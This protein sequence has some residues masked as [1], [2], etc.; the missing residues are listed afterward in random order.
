MGLP[1]YVTSKGR[2]RRRALWGGV[3]IL[4]VASLVLSL[5]STITPGSWGL[6][7]GLLQLGLYYFWVCLLL[8]RMH[9]LGR[10]WITLTVF[11]VIATLF[12]AFLA[13]VR[14]AAIALAE[15]NKTDLEAFR[16][17]MLTGWAAPGPLLTGFAYAA[18]TSLLWLGVASSQRKTNRYGPQPGV[19]DQAE[20]F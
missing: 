1:I 13:G 8:R 5:M 9:D 18:C 12:W 3:A 2:I 11:L 17:S 20:V 7:F 15:T 14:E 19:I 6:G 10:G 16:R 4:F